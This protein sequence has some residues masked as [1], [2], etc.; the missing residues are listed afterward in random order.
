[1]KRIKRQQSLS[2]FGAV[3]WRQIG[4]ATNGLLMLIATRWSMFFLSPAENCFDYTPVVSGVR[5]EW[6]ADCRVFISIDEDWT[7]CGD[8]NPG[9]RMLWATAG[10]RFGST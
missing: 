2:I 7:C 5:R 3:D 1:M 4:S 6:L 9:G 10:R 8:N